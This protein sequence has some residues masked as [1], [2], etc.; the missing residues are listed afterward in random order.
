LNSNKN[1]IVKRTPT[2]LIPLL[3]KEFLKSSLILPGKLG[4]REDVKYCS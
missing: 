1:S 2:K 4:I 3:L